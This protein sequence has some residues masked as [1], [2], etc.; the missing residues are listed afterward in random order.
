M[1]Y[2]KYQFL[3]RLENEAILPYYKGSTFRGV[4][5]HAMKKGGMCPQKT[6]M[7]P[8]SVKSEMRLYTGF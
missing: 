5:G 2:G 4:F 6:G 1:I 7:Q 3:C 8:V